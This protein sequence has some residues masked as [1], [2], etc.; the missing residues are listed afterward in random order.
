MRLFRDLTSALAALL[1]AAGAAAAQ[2]PVT[3]G[4]AEGTASFTIF[5]GSTVIGSEEVTVFRSGD[6]WR[7]S[8]T[9]RQRAPA[10]LVINSFELTLAA[11]WHPRELKID[12][13]LRDQPISSTTTFGVTTA[14]T[15]MMQ[16]GRRGS[17]THQISSRTIPLPNAFYAAYEV[18]AARLATASVGT[19]FKVFVVPQVEI[20]AV[21]KAV[22]DQKVVTTSGTISLKRYDLA[23]SNPGGELPLSIDVDSR[24]RLAR[25]VIPAA[26]LT[27]VR[28]DLSSVSSRPVTYRN[29]GDENVY[30]PALG[31][32]LA[33]TI[34]KPA[35][36]PAR[37]PAV[38]LI[39][40]SGPTDRDEMVAGIPIFGQ[41]AGQLANAGYMVL[42][43]DKRG[44]GQ[45]GGR[46]EAATLDE[47]ANDARAAVEWLSKRK[48]VDKN[49]IAVIGHSEGAA[50]G[51][52][53]ASRDKKIKAAV[54]IAGPGTRGY[55]LIL[56]QQRHQLDLMK[57]APADRDA[58]I[59][60]QR[61]LMDA[62]ISGKG[63]EG[64]APELRAQADSPWF[65][66]L[67]LFDPAAVIK[68]VRQPLLI[69]RADL[70]TQ[71]PS[72]HGDTLAAL[73]NARKKA[74]P[75]AIV[76]LK[77]VNHLL[78]PA[79][80]GEIS[81][82]ASLGGSKI[83]VEVSEAIANFLKQALTLR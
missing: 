26:Q 22:S 77:G 63:W 53:A 10:P 57:L 78:V 56:E 23:I 61:K 5:S 50:V 49:R 82:Y 42:R 4:P 17:V 80:T 24:G 74:A 7:V 67:L 11:D 51:L 20:D 72:H 41:L 75:A 45:S 25:V 69:I 60:L 44:V 8:S 55:E 28:D 64:V 48:D 13:L 34:T 31:F 12:A 46:P 76:T 54:L 3:A 68:K 73:A 59:A 70:D 19:T 38:V 18:F 66:S 62:V 52:I 14:V 43:Y 35:N 36:A 37:A 47:Y 71:V 81:E 1:F 65:R 30:V 27:V 21:V 15:D 79:K 9:G 29:P 58:R 6:V 83:S 39:G 2:T 16:N 32:N 33:A 40:G